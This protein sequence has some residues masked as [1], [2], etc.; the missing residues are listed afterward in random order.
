MKSQAQRLATMKRIALG[1]LALAALLYAA[2][3][4][5]QPRH[6]A[7]GY[8]AAFAEAAMVGAIADWFAVVALFRHPLGLPVP[9][10]AIIPAN[11]RRI[12][13][14]LANFICHNFLGT[15]QVLRKLR[16]FDP[17][18]QLAAWLAA[19]AH[20]AQVARHL[21][22][23]A[24]YGLGAFDDARVRHFV[25][26]L[27]VSG[28][29]RIEVS[30]VAGE[31]LD[32]LTAG[33]RHQA[34]LDEALAQVGT[35]LGDPEVKAR[36]AALIAVEL[37]LLR[38]VGLDT[39]AG[40]LA[41]EKVVAGVGRVI[42]EMGADEAHPLRLRFD[43]FMQRFIERLKDDPE[44]RERGERIKREALQ[45][46]ALAGYLHGLWSQLLDWLRADLARADSSI[47]A[48]IAEAAQ[49]LGAKLEAD[50]PMRQW[51]NDQIVAAAPQWIERYR[52]DIGRYIAGRVDE[53]NTE[54]LTDELERNIGRDLQF[55]R[56]NGTLVGGLVGLAIH[57]L[58]RWL[59]G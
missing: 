10:T 58:T 52:D 41:T 22:A 21:V 42:A 25:H 18:H 15:E 7:F 9:H 57:A 39:Y 19:P 6:P 29:E 17:A 56:V 37:K 14:N 43:E 11:K 13:E 49:T 12:G 35:L 34:L 51:I 44:F 28:L 4:A 26:D 55:V 53:W 59:G 20:A 3:T 30:R 23:A 33:R 16:A 32:A 48:R 24:R 8:V 36:L 46:P 54:E 50:A 31:V 2:A 40:Q 38:Y 27:A 47:A 1:L 45:Q 5:L